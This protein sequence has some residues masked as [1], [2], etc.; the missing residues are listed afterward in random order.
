LDRS[1]NAPHLTD[2]APAQRS[3]ALPAGVDDALALVDAGSLVEL[4]QELLAVPTVTGSAAESEGQHRL[5]SRL[6]DAGMDTDLWS[7]DLPTL[8]ADPE[9]PGMEAERDEAWGLVGTWGGTDPDAPT[10]VLNG[11]LDVVPSG[12]P[13]C[14]PSGRGPA[15]SA[16]ARCSAAA[17]AT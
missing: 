5:A 4:V 17:P 2:L 15:P 10:V 7:I 3:H 1:V 13:S 11:H 6:S 12:G 9:F 8:T 16:T 14:G